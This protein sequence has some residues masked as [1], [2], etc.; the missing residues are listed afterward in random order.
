MQ[1]KFGVD[2]ETLHLPRS[3]HSKKPCPNNFAVRWSSADDGQEIVGIYTRTVSTFTG[4]PIV[5]LQLTSN[6]NLPDGDMLK[7]VMASMLSAGR[8]EIST[9]G[10]GLPIGEPVPALGGSIPVIRIH[11]SQEPEIVQAL[12]KMGA[13]DRKCGAKTMVAAVMGTETI[14]DQK[15]KFGQTLPE[16]TKVD[17]VDPVSE[18][19]KPYF[20]FMKTPSEMLAQQFDPTRPFGDGH[21]E[22]DNT[23]RH[24]L[25]AA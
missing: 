25:R 23:A 1:P 19:Q 13:E 24:A 9:R 4:E 14:P 10:W 6:G 7:E 16:V 12:I 11:A 21:Y 18:A 22:N 2:V 17:G 15:E 8:A 5:R 3:R 20:G